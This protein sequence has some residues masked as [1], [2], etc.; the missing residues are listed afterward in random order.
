[1]LTP[2]KYEELQ[3]IVAQQ[4]IEA[5][6]RNVGQQIQLMVP[7]SPPPPPPRSSSTQA[8]T[9]TENPKNV[10]MSD[11][12]SSSSKTSSNRRPL[13]MPSARKDA[14]A[15][16][17]SNRINRLTFPYRKDKSELADCASNSSRS[18]SPPADYYR[19]YAKQPDDI[20]TNMESNYRLNI[21]AD[22]DMN[23]SDRLGGES[24]ATINK[25]RGTTPSSSCSPSKQPLSNNWMAAAKE[26]VT[27]NGL[28]EVHGGCYIINPLMKHTD[29]MIIAQSGGANDKDTFPDSDAEVITLGKGN[30]S[31]TTVSDLT[32][33]ES[34]GCSGK[35]T[36][37]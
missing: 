18:R 24:S 1:M 33:M 22:H 26:T 32:E 10:T 9:K 6:Q 25:L 7:P 21:L 16:K 19:T 2:E 29:R 35:T 11:D 27:S 12:D 37:M 31:T 4:R 14:K 23:N 8:Q 36:V 20:Y 17:K 13:S 15:L 30:D 28:Q 3:L 34:V 5:Q